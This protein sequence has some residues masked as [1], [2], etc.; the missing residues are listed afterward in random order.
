MIFQVYRLCPAN[1]FAFIGSSEAVICLGL[2]VYNKIF[3][4]LKQTPGY[5]YPETLRGLPTQNR[6]LSN[7]LLLKL[8]C[9]I[10]SRTIDSSISQIDSSKMGCESRCQ[11]IDRLTNLQ[12]YRDRFL[13][14]IRILRPPRSIEGSLFTLRDHRIESLP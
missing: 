11:I 4:L 13:D 7:L 3:C 14:A 2:E 9:S 12:S 1:S 8:I 6:L 10:K 5:C